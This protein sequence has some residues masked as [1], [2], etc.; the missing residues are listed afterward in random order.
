MHRL[1]RPQS[2]ASASD[3]A[4]ALSIKVHVVVDHVV[5]IA[6]RIPDPAGGAGLGTSAQYAHSRH[7]SWLGCIMHEIERRYAAD[8]HK[9]KKVHHPLFTTLTYLISYHYASHAVQF[10]C[11]VPSRAVVVESGVKIKSAS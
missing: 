7:W 9:K 8:L 4:L 6:I 2:I 10:R 5:A 1:S 3:I 11:S